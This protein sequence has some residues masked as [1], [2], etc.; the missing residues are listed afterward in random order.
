MTTAHS[1][2][3][4]GNT[5]Y[6]IVGCSLAALPVLIILC[7]LLQAVIRSLCHRFAAVSPSDDPQYVHDD[8]DG[9]ESVL[10][11][12]PSPGGSLHLP[13]TKGMLVMAKGSAMPPGGSPAKV[14]TSQTA[15]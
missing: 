12:P 11:T 2:V 9:A 3:G 10:A 15:K 14:T 7:C 5:I 13:L 4:G 8:D 1:A 6:I